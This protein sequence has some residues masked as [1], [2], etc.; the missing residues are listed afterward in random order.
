VGGR[1]P[2]DL[3]AQGHDMKV[4]YVP[5]YPDDATRFAGELSPRHRGPSRAVHMGSLLGKVA[6]VLADRTFYLYIAL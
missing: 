4:L 2:V 1:E 6:E 3:R 5:G